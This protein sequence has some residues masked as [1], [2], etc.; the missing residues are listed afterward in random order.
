MGWGVG[1]LGVGGGLVETDQN[2]SV[3]GFEQ[4]V[5]IAWFN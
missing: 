3:F 2:W 4:G 5:Q 1:C